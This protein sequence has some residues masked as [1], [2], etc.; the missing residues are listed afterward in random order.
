MIIA[1]PD[2]RQKALAAYSLVELIVVSG[3]VMLLVSL[4]VPSVL[5][6]LNAMRMSHAAE[7]I[8]ERLTEARGLAG[9]HNRDVEVRFYR[10][11]GGTLHEE[12]SGHGVQLFRIN[13]QANPAISRE[14]AELQMIAD[15]VEDRLPLSVQFSLNDE[16]TSIWKLPVMSVHTQKGL[17][18]YVAFRFRPDGSTDLAEGRK[19]TISLVPQKQAAASILPANFVVFMID[20]A[21]G[22]LSSFRPD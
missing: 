2:L 15:G 5:D 8:R 10:T 3:V 14:A 21:T 17:R 13:D 20:P 11:G 16:L 7:M 12:D 18:E 22:H 6:V 19:W 9:T 1:R 4:A